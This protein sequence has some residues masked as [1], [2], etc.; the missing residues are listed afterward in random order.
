MTTFVL[1]FSLWVKLSSAHIDH[2]NR[3]SLLLHIF[4]LCF[5][6]CNANCKYSLETLSSDWRIVVQPYWGQ[7]LI[8]QNIFV[9]CIS[10][11]F[12]GSSCKGQNVEPKVLSGLTTSFGTLFFDWLWS[13]SKLVNLEGCKEVFFHCFRFCYNIVTP[14]TAAIRGM[15]DNEMS[16][17]KSLPI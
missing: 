12:L 10:R 17:W 4:N 9:L 14:L 5:S 2:P 3:F 11:K 7:K 15:P 13:N 1:C 16:W 6:S 8:F